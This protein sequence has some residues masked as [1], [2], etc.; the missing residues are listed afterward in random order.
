MALARDLRYGWP[1]SLQYETAIYR[2]EELVEGC[3]G[4][5]LDRA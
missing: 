1:H 5:E 4:P 3:Y 2:L